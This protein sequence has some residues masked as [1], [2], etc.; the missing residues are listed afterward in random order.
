V[1]PAEASERTVKAIRAAD[2]GATVELHLLKD[3]PHDVRYGADD[4]LALPFLARFTRDAFPRSLRLRARRLEHARAFWVEVTEKSGGLAEVDGAIEGQTVALRTKGVKALR[5]LLRRELVDLGAPLRVLVDG[6][7]AFSGTLAED[8]A[9]FLAS[10]R[11]TGDP[12]RAHAAELQL[13]LP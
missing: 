7:E 5:L 1:I 10:W 11:A 4:D 12:Q 9:L 6:R 8:P 3:R 2:P 13:R